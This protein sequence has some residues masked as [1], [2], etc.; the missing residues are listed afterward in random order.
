VDNA[1][2]ND[3]LSA[4]D[5]VTMAT[6]HGA[7]A[8]GLDTKLGALEVGRLADLAVFHGDPSQPYAAIVAGAP[9]RCRAP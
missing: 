6:R 4:Q 9:V 7:Q 3:R 5:L 1:H 2:W 8:L